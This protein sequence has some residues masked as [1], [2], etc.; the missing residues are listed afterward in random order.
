MIR[1]ALPSQSFCLIRHGETTANADG[2][3]AGVTD[4]PLTAL[5]RNQARALAAQ[6]WPASIAVYTSPMTRALHT[7]RLAFPHHAIEQH[8]GLRER[9]WGAFEGRPLT[10]P[11]PRD[12]T[13]EHGESWPDMLNRVQN[14]IE[15]ICAA[16]VG[17]L[18]ILVCHSGI[19][20]TARVLWTTGD[21]GRRPPNA[22]PILF[23]KIGQT[24]SETPL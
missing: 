15:E 20:R 18:P 21:V 16:S 12:E 9:D 7:T 4:V 6:P 1:A 3:I 22:T 23:Q 5:G 24:L 11:P 14:T 19:I 8:H 17:R 13:P 2:I 10:E